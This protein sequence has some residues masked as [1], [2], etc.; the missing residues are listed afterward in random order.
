MK[1]IFLYILIAV[2]LISG[3]ALNVY[4]DGSTCDP[5]KALVQGACIV[6]ENVV[7]DQCMDDFYANNGIDYL[8]PNFPECG[9]SSSVALPPTTLSDLTQSDSLKNIYTLLTTN[10]TFTPIQA[11]AIMGNM[12]ADSRFNSDAHEPNN[13]IGYGL[14]MWSL[15]RRTALETYA[16]SLGTAS[17]DVAT[18]I[19][20]LI[21]E[22]NSTYKAKM[23]T[24]FLTGTDVGN[25]TTN[26]M[27]VYEG[28]LP[29][30][31]NL[32]TER[33]PA[34][35]TIFGF[36]GTSSSAPITTTTTNCTSG[37][38]V[39]QGNI[40]QT[41]IG[42][43]LPTPATDYKQVNK[44]DATQAYQTTKPKYTSADWTDCGGF[45]T[46]VLQSSG[47][48][49]K[50]PKVG[51]TEQLDYVKAHPEK[52]LVISGVKSANDL[53]P[54]DILLT[55]YTENGKP[56]GHTTIYTGAATYPSADA[57]LGQRVPSVRSAGSTT[58]MFQHNAYVARV[59]K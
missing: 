35:I 33:I 11:S 50:Y 14:L 41:A 21:N 40:V 29:D 18:Q 46:T 54:G 34:A 48:D 8:S 51:V 1:K 56:E 39:V 45:V 36:Y 6:C 28:V 42:L 58:W 43:A 20:F 57:S 9:D 16:K 25:A 17:S 24:D 53:K 44:G 59:I 52:Y 47:I 15:D 55:L 32:N 5:P 49:P 10:N 12:Y 37:S 30:T 13:D 26:W 31:A 38:G 4:A 7:N 3:T 27:T 2:T 22:Y 23:G 19:K